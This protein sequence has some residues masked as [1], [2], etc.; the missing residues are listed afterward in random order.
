[1]IDYYACQSNLLCVSIL[2]IV[3]F[4]RTCF[5]PCQDYIKTCTDVKMIEALGYSLEPKSPPLLCVYLSEPH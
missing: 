1:M 4:S 5:K 3:V 2:R